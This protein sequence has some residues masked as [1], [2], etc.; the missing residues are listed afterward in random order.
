M[1]V[2]LD[3]S[4]ILAYLDEDAAQHARVRQAWSSL[5]RVDCLI[6][7]TNYVL[8]EAS[9]V[10][11]RRAGMAAARTFFDAIVPLLEIHSV[12]DVTLDAA[13]QAW[14]GANRRDLRLVDIIS[15]AVMRHE[16]LTRA[17]TL[18]PHFAEQGFERLP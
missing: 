17:L 8:V 7:T 5:R 2:F 14:I 16:G 12:D 18:D 13:V 1:T 6:V 4:A 15:F 9:A 11:Q 10:L 3:T